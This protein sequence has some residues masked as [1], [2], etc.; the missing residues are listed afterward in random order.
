[1][2]YKEHHSKTKWEQKFSTENI[3]WDK[4]WKSL[5]NPI[6]SEYTKTLIWEQI[7]FNEYT[8]YSYNKWH[9]ANQ[10]CPLCLQHPETK[11]HITLQ[12][13][14]TISLWSEIEPHLQSIHPAN[15]TDTEK[16]FGILGDTPNIILRNWLTFTL[17]QCILEQERKAYYNKKGMQNLID[18]KLAYNQTIK[19][20]VWK[21]Y[22]IYKNLHRDGY[23]KR[24]FAVNDYLI[25][26]EDEQWNILTIFSVT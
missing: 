16:T 2:D 13:P 5:N 1:M 24:I 26:G 10:N 19:T 12:C 7:H 11:F 25:T 21:K 9:N 3:D 6:T 8:T 14:M 4:V 20:E 22:N 18:I 17:R 23:F 15:I